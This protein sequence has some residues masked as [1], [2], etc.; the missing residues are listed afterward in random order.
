MKGPLAAT[1][2]AAFSIDASKLKKPVYIVVTS[3]EETGLVGAKFVSEES[4]MLQESQ[5]EHGVIAEPT[6]M[7]P[8]YSHKGGGMVAVTA[9]GRA[10]HSSTGLGESAT[11]KI[12]PFLAEMAEFDQQLQQ[13]ASFMNEAFDPPHHTMNVTITDHGTALNVTAPRTTIRIMTRSMP[14]ARSDEVVEIMAN[15]AKAYGFEVESG[16]SEALYC[17]PSAEIVKVSCELTGHEAPQ[18]VPYGTDGL[19]LQ[20]SIKKLVVLGPGDIG[21]AHTVGEFVP[22]DELNQAVDVYTKMIERLC[23]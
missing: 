1:M 10:A 5:P 8:V 16:N 22:L 2:I 14:D 15:K 17:P 9:K 11:L 7:I 23:M 6:R 12:A 21:V 18:T 19:Y 3:D 13:D 4:K 20:N